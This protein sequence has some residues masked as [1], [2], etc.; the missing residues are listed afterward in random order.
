MAELMR[1]GNGGV[2]ESHRKQKE[3]VKNIA[4]MFLS[5]HG[6]D[7]SLQLAAKTLDEC[8]AEDLGRI[9][10]Y[11]LFASYLYNLPK[12]KFD[13]QTKTWVKGMTYKS[14]GTTENYFNTFVQLARAKAPNEADESNCRVPQSIV[15]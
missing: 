4:S 2:G 12:M 8:T 6:E 1:L 10:V 9:E 15:H 3:I 5:E 13:K 7:V 11:Q 14:G